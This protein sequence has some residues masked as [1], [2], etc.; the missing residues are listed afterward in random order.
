MV[1]RR[2]RCRV[3]SRLMLARLAVKLNMAPKRKAESAAKPAKAAK[4]SKASDTPAAASD[5]QVV[6]EACKS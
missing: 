4:A 1:D 6:I 5:A 2:Q 3:A